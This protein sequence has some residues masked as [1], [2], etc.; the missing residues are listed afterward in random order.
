MWVIKYVLMDDTLDYHPEVEF[1]KTRL[2]ALNRQSELEEQL[3]TEVELNTKYP[4]RL[5]SEIIISE[6]QINLMEEKMLSFHGVTSVKVTEP[7]L[8][9]GGYTNEIIISDIDRDYKIDLFSDNKNSL[10]ASNDQIMSLRNLLK[11]ITEPSI[12]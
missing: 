10:R 2:E 3:K 4:V 1:C 12:N 8:N 5:C 11:E 9:S 6:L 7:R